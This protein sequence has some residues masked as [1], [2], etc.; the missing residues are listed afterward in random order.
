MVKMNDEEKLGNGQDIICAK[1]NISLEVSPVKF[2]YVGVAF[3]VSLFN[4]PICGL[5]YVPAVLAR[6]SMLD[7]QRALEDK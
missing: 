6:G 3:S 2:N 7:V 4:C 5:T 1:C